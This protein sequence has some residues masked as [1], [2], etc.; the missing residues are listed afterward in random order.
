M[1]IAKC[2]GVS[3]SANKSNLE[4]T[5]SDYCGGQG[6]NKSIISA[7]LQAVTNFQINSVTREYMVL[8]NTHIGAT[9]A[10]V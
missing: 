9:V 3:A 5:Y 6:V 1:L 4:I 10:L 2:D 8:G 7:Y